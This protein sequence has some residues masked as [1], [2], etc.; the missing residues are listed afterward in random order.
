MF[1]FK[2]LIYLKF[3]KCFKLIIGLNFPFGFGT[4]K[5]FETYGA[6]SHSD[7]IIAPLSAKF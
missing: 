7:L 1:L 6:G 2:M 3:I 5:I 4:T